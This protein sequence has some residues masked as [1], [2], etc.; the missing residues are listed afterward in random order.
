MKSASLSLALLLIAASSSGQFLQPGE[1]PPDGTFAA[2]VD[3]E[4]TF[5]VFIDSTESVCGKPFDWSESGVADDPATGRVWSAGAGGHADYCGNE[6]YLY[7]FGPNSWSRETEPTPLTGRP[8]R[9]RSDDSDDFYDS[10]YAPAGWPFASL[11]SHS[12]GNPTFVPAVNGRLEEQLLAL[13]AGHFCGAVNGGGPPGTGQSYFTKAEVITIAPGYPVTPYLPN[14]RDFATVNDPEWLRTDVAGYLPE[15]VFGR[16]KTDYDSR[17]DRLV[18]IGVKGPMWEL[19]PGNDYAGFK[20]QGVGW[21]GSGVLR[22]DEARDV[23][24]WTEHGKGL[25]SATI[26]AAG[27]YGPE[28]E[29]FDYEGTEFGT[30]NGLSIHDPTGAVLV[31]NNA[32]HVLWFVPGPEDLYVLESGLDVDNQTRGKAYRTGYLPG[33]DV[34]WILA[35][36]HLVDG[37]A[38]DAL[39]PVWLFSPPTAAQ[40]A[41]MPDC[42]A[43]PEFAETNCRFAPGD[44]PPPPGLDLTV[45]VREEG[46]F[47]WK[48]DGL[49]ILDGEVVDST[50]KDGV[51]FEFVGDGEELSLEVLGFDIDHGDE[52]EVFLNGTSLGHLLQGA[53]NNHSPAVDTFTLPASLVVDGVN[54]L[55]FRQR[56]S[57]WRW[58][59]TD[60]LVS[61]GSAPMVSSDPEVELDPPPGD[62]VPELEA[63]STVAELT[64]EL[65]DVLARAGRECAPGPT[66]APDPDPDPAPAPDPEPV[67]PPLPDNPYPLGPV[68]ELPAGR[69]SFEERC[70]AA[71]VVFCDPLDTEGPYGRDAAGEW[72]VMPNEDGSLGLPSERWWRR[73]RGVAQ[74]GA[75]PRFRLPGLDTAVKRS[76][77]GSLRFHY[78]TR[79]GPTGG[80]VF[81]T[82]FS[83]D[84]S[85]TFGPGDRLFIQYS[86]RHTCDALFLECDPSSPEYKKKRRHFRKNPDNPDSWTAAKQT[87]ISTGDWGSG[88]GRGP[89]F[90]WR[91]DVYESSN[92]CTAHEV[93]LNYSVGHL[94]KGYHSCRGY[95]GFAEA[96]GR[97]HG[98]ANKEYQN[99]RGCWSI[100][101][102]ELGRPVTPYG[103]DYTGPN[104]FI[105]DSDEWMTVLVGLEFGPWQ[106]G[107]GSDRNARGDTIPLSRYSLWAAHE[108]DEL[109]LLHR[110]LFFADDMTEVSWRCPKKAELDEM[111]EEEAAA[112]LDACTAPDPR[113]YGKIWLLPYMTNKDA[114]EEH[115]A[116][117]VYYDELVV[118]EEPIASPR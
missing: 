77:S 82:N 11:S 27:N 75:E 72:R 60:I 39:G 19:D 99:A 14:E 91:I 76:G 49:G 13:G 111:T 92:A 107:R 53:N 62:P 80:G 26:D 22:I 116:F 97:V 93:V 84:L 101:E 115:P 67:P 4:P 34:F 15:K 98:K 78:P 3:S 35:D 17:R 40:L 114:T 2:R 38:G 112:A 118:S 63:I 64:A 88:N 25:R 108:G 10:C 55:E 42:G 28:V 61:D 43:A 94:F 66:P 83:D 33:D 5:D 51:T 103:W 104:C 113:E 117:D 1:R 31:H 8:L 69:Q 52:V 58:G 47:G 86:I 23:M 12:Y 81:A 7:E 74:K 85:R 106:P 70:A 30:A 73:W 95:K 16:A 96:I 45:N 87:I 89:G 90:P 20:V 65:C 71:G 105:L 24:W 56:V 18:V 37:A 32:E 21:G 79:S 54:A 110:V 102:P 59:V 48:L 36:A 57:G 6:V 46:Y 100:P 9:D 50:H 44:P 41:A 68:P 29:R 109:E